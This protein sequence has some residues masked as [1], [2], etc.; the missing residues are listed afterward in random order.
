MENA[1]GYSQPSEPQRGTFHKIP[2]DEFDFEQLYPDPLDSYRQCLKPSNVVIDKVNERPV[3]DSDCLVVEWTDIDG[4]HHKI[5]YL[6]TVKLARQG[7]GNILTKLQDDRI[8]V[9]T[10]MRYVGDD[11]YHP[12]LARSFVA[13]N[14]GDRLIKIWKD[15]VT[16]DLRKNHSIVILRGGYRSG[17][18]TLAD[19]MA[20]LAKTTYRAQFANQKLEGIT[21][22]ARRESVEKMNRDLIF[23]G[24][25]DM[26]H[27]D[28]GKTLQHF[29]N[30]QQEAGEVAIWQ[31]GNE[32][33]KFDPGVFVFCFTN[34]ELPTLPEFKKLNRM[35]L[36]ID[37]PHDFRYSLEKD[38]QVFVDKCVEQFWR[39]NP[40]L[41]Q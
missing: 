22:Q 20:K 17:K 2:I 29:H 30:L 8:E 26:K 12:R 15:I 4:R 18:S 5:R 7:L 24:E 25:P 16:G 19:I 13:A 6:N 31:T 34:D 35:P 32:F 14:D 10:L 41:K 37:L 1:G 40:D 38:R 21:T 27:D 11:I 39:E 28:I 3:P 33:V 23:V 9:K 36:I